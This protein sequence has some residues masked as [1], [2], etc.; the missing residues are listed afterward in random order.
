MGKSIEN[1][2]SREEKEV[3][4]TKSKMAARIYDKGGHSPYLSRCQRERLPDLGIG[5]QTLPRLQSGVPRQARRSAPPSGRAARGSRPAGSGRCLGPAANAAAAAAKPPLG[6]PT[7]R[8]ATEVE[9]EAPARA[10]PAQPQH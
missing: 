7:R 8:P 10:K 2:T 9:T 3:R 4:K 1:E 5:R 6:A